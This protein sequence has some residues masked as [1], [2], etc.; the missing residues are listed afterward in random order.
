MHIDLVVFNNILLESHQAAVYSLHCFLKEKTDN[1][2]VMLTLNLV[3]SDG[4]PVLF[5]Y[6]IT[7]NKLHSP[8]IAVLYFRLLSYSGMVEPPLKVP[9]PYGGRLV[10]SL[11]GD[12]NL[13]VH[14]KDK[15]KI[16]NKKRWS[17]VSSFINVI[18]PGFMALKTQ[19]NVISKF[20]L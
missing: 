6:S 10:F 16:R 2:A 19:R 20:I 17:M 4:L 8:T 14:L 5:Q 3:M 7:L 15:L 11:P 9:T 1:A 18:L 12:N 13:V